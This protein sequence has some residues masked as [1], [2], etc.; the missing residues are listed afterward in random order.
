MIR[1]Q[2]S[3][4]GWSFGVLGI[5]RSSRVDS[6]IRQSMPCS[7][8]V[9]LAVVGIDGHFL[10][11]I[12][13]CLRSVLIRCR[14]HCESVFTLDLPS[15]YQVSIGLRRNLFSAC[16]LSC[17]SAQ[18]VPFH[19][20]IASYP[21]RGIVRSHQPSIIVHD[22]I[23]PPTHFSSIANKPKT[24]FHRTP[25]LPKP[26]QSNQHYIPTTSTERPRSIN[27]PRQSIRHITSIRPR[28]T[29]ILQQPT[30][31][32]APTIVYPRC[33]VPSRIVRLSLLC[34]NLFEAVP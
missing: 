6:T 14:S 34:Q 26:Q 24:H 33:P 16:T 20:I 25:K 17:S 5:A 22:Y 12:K 10:F 2:L 4:E 7:Y 11:C 21:F 30:S 31:R 15:C 8:R 18:V 28:T 23:N 27:P 32:K 3:S 1:L 29:S 9:A 19:I 13:A